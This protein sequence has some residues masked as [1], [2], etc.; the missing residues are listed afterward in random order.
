MYADNISNIRVLD[1]T[2]YQGNI[3]L[4][5]TKVLTQE[6]LEVHKSFMNP[7]REPELFEFDD[8]GLTYVDT[9]LVESDDLKKVRQDMIDGNVQVFRLAK[10]HNYKKIKGDYNTSGLNLRKKPIQAVIDDDGNIIIIFNGNTSDKILEEFKLQN[11]F[12][13]IFK[14]NTKYSESNLRRIAENQNNLEYSFGAGDDNTAEQTVRDIVLKHKDYTLPKKYSQKQLINFRDR[15]VRDIEYSSNG[16]YPIK[17]KKFDKFFNSLV[18][19]TTGFLKILS[20]DSKDKAKSYLIENGVNGS[21]YK[22]SKHHHW[23]FLSCSHGS[24]HHFYVASYCKD[25]TK[26]NKDSVTSKEWYGVN[27]GYEPS[28]SVVLYN[29]APSPIETVSNFFKDSMKYHKE[30]KMTEEF[31]ANKFFHKGTALL[32]NK[33]SSYDNISLY[34]QSKKLEEWANSNGYN[35]EGLWNFNSLVPMKEVVRVYNLHTNN[36]T[37]P[38]TE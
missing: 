18:T 6:H 16:K 35:D 22:N 8:L 19:E 10:N 24:K 32:T 29:T 13:A 36:E 33:F 20:F 9:I 21:Q 14:K 31:L 15:V 5:K 23:L 11:R 38:F 27:E 37:H 28:V 25:P 12:I 17:S 34:Q 7:K 1:P 26:D 30:V 3:N 2:K 4:E